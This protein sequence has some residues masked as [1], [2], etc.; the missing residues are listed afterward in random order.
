MIEVRAALILLASVGAGVIA[1]ALRL[2]AG[3][4]WPD[5]LLT[6]GAAAGAAFGLL[7]VAVKPDNPSDPS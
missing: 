7:T 2:A 6:A 5:A 1:G 4:S 3:A